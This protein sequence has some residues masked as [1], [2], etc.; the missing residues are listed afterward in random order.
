[1]LPVSREHLAEKAAVYQYWFQ[2]QHRIQRQMYWMRN[3]Y[4]TARTSISLWRF[5]LKNQMKTME[6]NTL[7]LAFCHFTFGEP[8]KRK[9]VCNIRKYRNAAALIS[10][11]SKPK[12]E[13]RGLTSVFVP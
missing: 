5:H 2:Q 8:N 6:V 10:L 7:R 3:L 1:M 11:P 4:Q 12:V 9:V 13:V